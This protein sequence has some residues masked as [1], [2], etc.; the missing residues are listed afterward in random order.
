ML[1]DIREGEMPEDQE[2]RCTRGGGPDA[3]QIFV[4]GNVR[5]KGG[6]A[7]GGGPNA[8]QILVGGNVRGKGGRRGG[9]GGGTECTPDFRRREFEGQGWEGGGLEAHRRLRSCT[10]VALAGVTTWAPSNA[11]S[12]SDDSIRPVAVAAK[13]PTAVP[14]KVQPLLLQDIG[15]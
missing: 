14:A 11:I 2:A 12:S 1:A 7:G 15:M 4:G 9:V 8:H 10:R 6:S 3:H 13:E 5:G